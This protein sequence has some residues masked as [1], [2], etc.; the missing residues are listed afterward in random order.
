MP[1]AQVALFRLDPSKFAFVIFAAVKLASNKLLSLKLASINEAP[2]KFA[3][4]KLALVKLVFSKFAPCKLDSYKFALMKDD[5]ENVTK[6]YY[7][8]HDISFMKI[9]LYITW[10]R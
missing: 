3:L 5:S 10:I 8:F 2:W 6:C 1:S 4:V 7:C 9:F